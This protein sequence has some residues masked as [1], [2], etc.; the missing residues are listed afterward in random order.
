MWRSSGAELLRRCGLGALLLAAIG[1]APAS[2]EVATVEVEGTRLTAPVLE[3]LLRLQDQWLVWNSAFLQGDRVLAWAGVRDLR[4]TAD[5]M[6]L[7]RLP[8]PALGMSVR[9]IESARGGDFERARWALEMASELDAGAPEWSFAASR[10]AWLDRAPIEAVG[11]LARGYSTV[12]RRS[13]TS[14][15][16]WSDVVLWLAVSLLVSAGLFVALQMVTKGPTL[17]RDLLASL[18]GMLPLPIAALAAAVAMLWPLLLPDGWIWLLLQWSVLL[19]GYGSASER[20]ATVVAIAIFCGAPFA[21]VLQQRG[22]EIALRPESRLLD[23]LEQGALH[24]RLFHDL[25]RLRE[26]LPDTPALDQL[27]A[28]IHVSLGQDD[29]ARPIYR[30]VVD[31][32]PNNGAA[33]NNLGTFH[34]FRQEYI[35]ALAYFRGAAD[36]PD[37]ALAAQYNLAQTYRRLMEFE[38]DQPHIDAARGLDGAQVDRWEQDGRDGIVLAG[39]VERIE[40]IRRELRAAIGPPPLCQRDLLWLG[41]PLGVLALGSMVRWVARPGLAL[42]SPRDSTTRAGSDRLLR[43][44]VPGLLSSQAGDGGRAFGAVLVPVAALLLPFSEV[45]GFAVPWGLDPGSWLAW[46][47]GLLVLGG[48]LT[49]RW[50]WR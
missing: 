12:F 46:A 23:H 39:G 9:A 31:R 24:G 1:G 4:S 6:G 27:V 2:A 49:L 7:H 10:V 28:D 41:L 22:T 16:W 18:G 26:A 34:F 42:P 37:S 33:L 15:L 44:L 47:V 30:Q 25:A 35:E 5:E 8:E 3:T 14:R 21:V 50:V 38:R 11:H 45:L 17:L 43:L 19:W 20:W 13:L 32:E 36:R 29:L 40:E 48:Y